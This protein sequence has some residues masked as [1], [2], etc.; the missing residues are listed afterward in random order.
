MSV[1]LFLSLVFALCISGSAWAEQLSGSQTRG[2]GSNG[3]LRST[4]TNLP[5]SG[6]VVGVSCNGDGFWI[7]SSS[8]KIYRFNRGGGNGTILPPGTYRAYPNLMARQN[9]ANVSITIQLSRAGAGEDVRS[10][11]AKEGRRGSGAPRNN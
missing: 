6:T 7:E 4:P 1:R 3:Q 2:Q 10:S 5:R 11:G 8:G 9:Q